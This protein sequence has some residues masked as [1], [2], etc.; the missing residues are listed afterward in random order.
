M[1]GVIYIILYTDLS[2]SV[3][4]VSCRISCTL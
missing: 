2:H 1:L 4:V 3:S